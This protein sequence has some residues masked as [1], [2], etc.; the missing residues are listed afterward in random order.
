MITTALRVPYITAWSDEEMP[1]PL[2][3]EFSAEVAGL[4][5]TY[6]DP[7]PEDWVF[8]VL[9]AR[10]GILRGGRPEWLKVNTLRQWQCMDHALCQVCG[11]PAA[12]PE[13]GRIWWLL[14]DADGTGDG[15]SNAPPT[16]KSCIPE[17][18]A[19]C[20]RLR[21]NA[22]VCSVADC[23]PFAVLGDVFE[24]GAGGAN[25]VERNVLVGLDEFRALA[26]V[27]A[28]QLVVT[29]HGLREEPLP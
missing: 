27:L 11:L 23:E 17:A 22:S 10:H 16:C 14:T 15:Y 5:L 19:S 9:R 20:P 12:D 25:L 7:H 3:F 2:A 8:G 6:P 26:A 4:R 28:Q 29:L 13:T 18:I 21:S 1:H 24:F